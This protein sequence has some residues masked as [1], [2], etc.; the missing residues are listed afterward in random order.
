MDVGDEAL[1]VGPGA[2]YQAGGFDQVGV[3]YRIDNCGGLNTWI[4]WSN[5]YKANYT[6]EDPG[7]EYAV[8]PVEDIELWE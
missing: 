3:V 4:E 8:K 7:H 5:G 1:P 6:D 2:V